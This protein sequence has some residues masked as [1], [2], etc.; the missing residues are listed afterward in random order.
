MRRDWEP[1][2]LVACW[3]LID[4]DWLLMA[5]KSGATRLGFALLLQFFEVE[6]R[7]P[8]H[9]RRA[10]DRGGGV[11]RFS[12]QGRPRPARWLRLGRDGRSSITE[13]RSATL[14]VSGRQPGPMRKR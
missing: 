1:E 3:T 6:A 10:P 14:S 8:R 7:F 13:A 12:D 5:N 4:A 9:P 2:D 11:C